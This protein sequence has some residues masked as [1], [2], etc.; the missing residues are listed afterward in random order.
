MDGMQSFS[1]PENVDV[2]TAC[3]LSVSEVTGDSLR[4]DLRGEF[5]SQLISR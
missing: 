5:E 2:A 3:V 4:Q 1:L